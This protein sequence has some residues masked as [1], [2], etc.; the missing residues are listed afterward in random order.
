MSFD[1]DGNGALDS[2]E[3]ASFSAELQGL[4][5]GSADVQEELQQRGFTSPVLLL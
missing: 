2:A 4:S 1:A 5:N 3:G